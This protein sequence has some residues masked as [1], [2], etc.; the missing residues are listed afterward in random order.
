MRKINNFNSILDTLRSYF[1]LQVEI[2][3][4]TQTC[5][6]VMIPY[7]PCSL[8]HSFSSKILFGIYNRGDKI[9]ISFYLY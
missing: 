6:E 3:S 2:V 8:S 5:L 9:S 1:P 7:F 4:Q